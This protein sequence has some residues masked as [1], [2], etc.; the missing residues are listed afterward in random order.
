MPIEL[1]PETKARSMESIRHFFDESLDDEIGDL[2]ATLVLEFFLKEIAPTV[3]NQAI[4]DAQAYLQDKVGLPYLYGK[5]IMM[6]DSMSTEPR[7]L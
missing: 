2:K 6:E 5:C 4:V 1:P 7:H 3:Y